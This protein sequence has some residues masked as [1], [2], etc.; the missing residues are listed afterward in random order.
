MDNNKLIIDERKVYFILFFCVLCWGSNF[1]FGEVLVSVFDPITI[2]YLRLFFINIFLLFIGKKYYKEVI[3]NFKTLSILAL[4]GFIGVTLNQWSFYASLQYTNPVTAALILAMAPIMTSLITYFYLKEKRKSLFWISLI[5]SF[6][7]VWFVITGGDILSLSFGKGE[8]LITLT[9][10]TFSV[11]LVMVQQLSKKINPMTIT[12]YS[13]AFGL[14]FFIPLISAKDIA[15]A[16]EV[17]LEYWVLL[18]ITAVLM[19]GICIVLWNN[20]LQKVGAAKASIL[21]NFEPFIV[22]ILGYL[23]L[24]TLVTPIQFVGSFLI[25][26]G[27]ITS[28]NELQIYNFIK[29][30]KTNEFKG[31]RNL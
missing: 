13:N 26:V 2:S 8:L 7:G 10:I 17:K 5:V 1:I 11:F 20:S 25:I 30:R 19:H 22:M 27:V 24:K 9:M 4:A 21:M 18:I 3:L 14:L 12:V 6:A 23:V 31:N 16:L 15:I 28:T 29:R